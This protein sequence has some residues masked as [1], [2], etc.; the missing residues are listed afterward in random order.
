MKT[1]HC[2][3]IGLVAA[4]AVLLTACQSGKAPSPDSMATERL[5]PVPATTLDR[6]HTLGGIFLASQPSEVELAELSDGG[7]KTVL[8]LRPAAEDRGYDEA[9]RAGELGLEYLNLP[10]GGAD[11]LTDEVFDRARGIFERGQRPMLVHCKSANRVGALWLAWRATDGGLTLEEALAEAK[12]VGL[13]SEELEAKAREY[14]AS[15]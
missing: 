4:L 8:D 1:L 7:I 9:Q 11:D 13:K 5:A 14:V 3:W 6:M 15:H 12:L 10:I 2:S